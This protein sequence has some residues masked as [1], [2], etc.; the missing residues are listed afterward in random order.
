MS[1]PH[2]I[3][4]RELDRLAV[5]AIIS[6]VAEPV[7]SLV[8]TAFVGRL[9]TADLA[10]VG[11]A[12]SFFLLVLWVLAQ[13]RSA[14]LAVVARY[15]GEKRIDEVRDLVP[16][17]IWMNFGL[18]LLFFAVTKSFA[19]P[20][21]RLYNADGE[22]LEKAVAYYNVRA[23]GHPIAL[24]TF[25]LSGAFRGLQNL[26]WSM[27]ISLLGAAV[28]LVLNPLL[29]FG[30][31]GFPAWGIEGSAVASLVAQVV[32]FLVSAQV[33]VTRTPFRLFPRT[34][35]HP[36]VPHL[37]LLSGNLF[38]RTMALNACYYLG[39]RY[40]TGYG[41]AYIGA[42]SIA[43]QIWLFSAFFIDGYAAAGSVLAG[44]FNGEKNWKALYRV[45]W[46]V[47]QRSIGIGVVLAAIYGAAYPWVGPLFT[48]DPAVLSLFSA[49]FWLVILTQPINAVAFAFDGIYKGLGHG[50]V[51]R[52]ALLVATFLVFV[53]V[54]W[55][56]DQLDWKLFAVWTAFLLWMASRSVQLTLDFRRTYGR[57]ARGA[58]V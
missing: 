43:M 44:R 28:N 49:V 13:T 51:L 31:L 42:H 11:I 1:T 8:D 19:E 21:F 50:E 20:I 36:E 34:W 6:G 5:P 29:I 46:Q 38:A 25:A 24:A 26:K 7:I 32:M 39:N 17:A 23:W 53:P 2:P 9:G 58:K 4:K 33:L 52:N 48:N 37:L 10:A 14:V 18:G 30:M 54:I 27:W 3:T 56:L 47:V 16:I 45:S 22:I 55:G 40:A 12:S 57:L 15:Y 35:W 41:Q